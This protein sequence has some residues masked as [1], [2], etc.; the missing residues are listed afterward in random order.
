MKTSRAKS[1]MLKKW[2]NEALCK[3]IGHQRVY[4]IEKKRKVKYG[5]SYNA[6]IRYDV[7]KVCT[8]KRCFK[9]LSREKLHSNI[10]AFQYMKLFEM[11]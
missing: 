1:A 10:D 7:F 2:I 3:Y 4:W 8:C 5:S 9:E 11:E 6:K